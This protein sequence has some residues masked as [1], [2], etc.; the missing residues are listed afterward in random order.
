VVEDDRL[1][2]ST[3]E[4]RKNKYLVL[5]KYLAGLEI[6]DKNSWLGRFAGADTQQLLSPSI[7]V[8]IRY[9]LN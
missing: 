1:Y 5:D 3:I 6:K 7:P 8:G 2:K 9:L 4:S